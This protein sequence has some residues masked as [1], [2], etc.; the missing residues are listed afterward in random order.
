MSSIKILPEIIRNK[1]AAGEVVARPASVVKELVENSID[2]GATKISVIIEN[3]GGKLIS[4]IDN[5]CGMDADDSLLC[6]E[7]HATSKIKTTDDLDIIASFGFRGEALPSIASVSRFSMKT[8]RRDD[9]EG[10]KVVVNG[11]KFIDASP[12]GCAAGTEIAVRDLFYNTPARRRFMRA[13]AT[14]E[15]HIHETIIMLALPHREVSFDLTLDGRRVVAAPAANDM[16]T[17]LAAIFGRHYADQLICL[18]HFENGIEITGFIAKH[19]FTRPSRK[20]QRTFINKRAVEAPEIFRGIAQGY[21][22]LLPK[23]RYAPAVIFISMSPAMVDVNVH[24]AKKEVRLRNGNLTTA[25][26][27]NAVRGALR[28]GGSPSTAVNLDDG[29]S[30]RSLLGGAML[31]YQPRREAETPVLEI[32]SHVAPASS[33]PPENPSPTAAER[34]PNSLP[35]SG[36]MNIIGFLFDTY[37]VATAESG[38]LIIDQHAAHERV[39]FE[40]LLRHENGNPASQRL[41]LP[42]TFEPPRAERLFLERNLDTFNELGFEISPFGN[43]TMLVNAIPAALP[44]D[45]VIGVLTDIIDSLRNDTP[46]PG[47]AVALDKIATAACKAAVKANDRLSL[48]EAEGLLKQMTACE[49]PYSC[50]HGR[51]TI[52]NISPAELEKRF[53]RR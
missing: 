4:V 5:G 44:Q 19:G 1:I 37:I 16:K 29:L 7:T 12:A 25:A 33:T 53:G 50:P 35:G 2:A 32:E 48:T 39:M 40:R 11:G 21:D 34:H 9:L 28:G 41:L 52:I 27:A 17:R 47:R 31:D 10:A 15:R 45:N 18:Q 20:E 46:Q 8:K 23:G 22:T 24:P 38:L 36:G 30:L 13:Q 42:I 14:E 49:H 43:D 3:G 51:P 26:V 6:L